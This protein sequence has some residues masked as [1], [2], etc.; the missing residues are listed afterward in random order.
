M[1][2]LHVIRSNR[3]SMMAALAAVVLCTALSTDARAACFTSPAKGAVAAPKAQFAAQPGAFT[4][5]GDEAGGYDSIVGLWHAEFL[6]GTGPDKY[7]ES[8]QQFHADKSELMISNGVPP[9][10]GNVCIGIWKQEGRNIVLKHMT[11]NWDLDGHLTGS[12]VMM[13]TVRLGSD[14]KSYRGR[15]TADSFDLGGNVIDAAHAEGIVRATRITL[16]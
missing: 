12:F 7:D 13:V 10:L 8:F 11:W 1:T 5:G 6:L 15:W 14:G 16:D 2:L 3:L 9:V 4:F